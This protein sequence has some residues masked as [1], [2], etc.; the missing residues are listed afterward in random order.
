MLDRTLSYFLLV[1]GLGFL[2]A[3]LRLAVQLF[4]ALRLK[5]QAVLTWPVPRPPFY[6]LVVAIA[7][8]L[9]ILL[10]VEMVLRAK[11]RIDRALPLFGE[12]MMF[13]YYAWMLPLDRQRI[14]RGFYA[15]GV[16][17]DSGFIPYTSIGGLTWR[18]EPEITL[19]VV[20]RMKKLAR[21]LVVPSQY[22]A[23]AR[24]LLRDK[25]AEHELHFTGKALD[26]GAHDERDDV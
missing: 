26:L 13:V 24:R 3:N 9:G 4:R 1:L 23:E 11:W 22:Y 6:G 21:T 2:L 16:W 19:I 12:T 15:D 17:A 20:P 18:E 8:V 7:I 5:S 14:R 10:L 25:I